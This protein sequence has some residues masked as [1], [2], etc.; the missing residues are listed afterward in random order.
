MAQDGRRIDDADQVHVLQFGM[1]VNVRVGD[2][3]VI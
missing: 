2:G 1:H 3:Q